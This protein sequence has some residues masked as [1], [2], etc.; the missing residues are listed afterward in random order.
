MWIPCAEINELNF[1]F[2]ED[3][4]IVLNI[5]KIRNTKIG[6]EIPDI[7]NLELVNIDEIS[8]FK[9]AK[10]AEEHAAGRFLLHEMLMKYYPSIEDSFVEISRDVN[11]APYFKWIE[12]TF[13][14]SPLPNFSISTS[15]DF[16][17]VALCSSRYTIGV[18]IEKLNQKRSYSLFDFLS[19]GKELEQI[20]KLYQI[21]D[22]SGINKF[23][24]AKESI[25]KALRL[26]MS[27]SPTRIKIID[28]NLNYKS[29]IE[30]EGAYLH[31]KTQI[32]KL[33]EDY[34]FSLAF[35]KISHSKIAQV[36]IAGIEPTT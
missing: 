3:V 15:G 5:L 16:V 32:L 25:L 14:C 23:W 22:N 10:R 29:I 7:S 1:D 27:I 8:R 35:K 4:K 34:S 19:T 11:R 33:N 36:R 2:Q 28:E 13:N 12:G 20:K 26:G 30:Y 9:T 17:I 24:T 31:L 18:D 6:D 21:N